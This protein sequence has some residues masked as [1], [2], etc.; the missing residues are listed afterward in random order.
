MKKRLAF[1][2]AFCMVSSAGT[3]GIETVQAEDLP[4]YQFKFSVTQAP[5]D[6]IAVYAQQM[7]DEIEEKTEGR[8]QIE[9]HT[10]G[11][12]GAIN[13]VNEMIAMGAEIINYTGADAF[14][15]TVP[16]LSILNCQYC[17]SD[18][19]QMSAIHESDWYKEQ[20]ETLGQNGNVRLLC[21]N[22]FT[23]YRHFVSTFPIE[24][25]EDLEGKQMRVADAAALI[26][27]SK[28]LG[29]SPVVTN[30]NETYTALS[31]G[32]VECAEAPLSTL[33]SSSL[34]E[35]TD[36]LTLT[37][38][39]VSCGG[40]CMNEE[41]FKGMPESYQQIILDAAW[42]AGEAFTENSL[43]LEEEYISKFE[44]AGITVTEV[45]DEMLQ[46]FMEK[47]SAMYEDPSLGFTEGLYDEIQA[48]INP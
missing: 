10:N 34:Q 26:A 35:V 7:I 24:S 22:W 12:L 37:G 25:V 4:E 39:L 36:Y 47:A 27:F 15:A 38:H 5:T 31:Q 46:T 8:I 48:I 16:D 14:N 40:I 42:N 20:I 6:P 45:E 19:S 21:Y 30:W 33:Y 9:L 43:G 11:E 18:P 3:W 29:C 28:A 1:I 13:D 41:I 17:L 32:M 44:E 2:L 23:G